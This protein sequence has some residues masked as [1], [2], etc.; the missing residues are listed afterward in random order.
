M[1]LALSDIVGLRVLLEYSTFP[2]WLLLAHWT[3]QIVRLGDFVLS[4]PAS[5]TLS[6]DLRLKEDPKLGKWE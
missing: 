4:E 1:F 6:P 5:P 3:S 2:V